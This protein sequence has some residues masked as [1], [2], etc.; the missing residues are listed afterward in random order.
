[1]SLATDAATLG[2]E[3]LLAAS[4]LALL[5]FG[6]VGG[7]KRT[8]L[9]SALAVAAMVASGALVVTGSPAMAFHGA[10]VVDAFSRYS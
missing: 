6:A 9:V 10:F 7:D 5:L 1:M 2:P 8:A 3:L 4:G